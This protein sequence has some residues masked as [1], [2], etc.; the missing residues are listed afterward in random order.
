MKKENVLLLSCVILGFAILS[1]SVFTILKH[2][3]DSNSS[4]SPV[5]WDGNKESNQNLDEGDWN[6]E[7]DLPVK[8]IHSAW[9]PAFDFNKGFDSLK[10]NYEIFS[11]VNPVFYGVNSNG[12]LLNRKPSS[13]KL[14]EFINFCKENNVQIVPTIGAFDSNTIGNVLSS[15]S[16]INTHIDEIVYEI[17]RYDF[18]G[19]DIDYE[20]IKSNKKDSYLEFLTNLADKLHQ[21]DKFLS[22]TVVA[23]TQEGEKDTLFVQDWEK[24]GDIADQVRIMTYDYTLQTDTTPGPIGP[25]DW[26]LDVVK[27]AKGKIPNEK[28]FLGIHLYA[29]LWED[30][31]ASALTHTSVLNILNDS[32]IQCSYKED[33][34][35]GYAKYTCNSD[36]ECVLYYQTK[37]GI[38]ERINIAKE[39]SYAGVAYWRLGEE[40]DLFDFL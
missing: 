26:I 24:I 11:I 27:Y 40:G 17:E 32:L 16:F 38:A 39:N 30:G 2:Q 35:E 20:K 36:K 6:Q 15:E 31:H 7:L 4:V 5:N 34:G 9:I 37:K 8:F 10:Q 21:K 14:Q 3:R 33:L 12:T 22:V 23:K 1:F 29:Y 18:D 19:I 28:I 13:E 25:K